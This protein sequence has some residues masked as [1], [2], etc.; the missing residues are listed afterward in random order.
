MPIQRSN[1]AHHLA[2]H[3]SE[4][5]PAVLSHEVSDAMP[6]EIFNEHIGI[7]KRKTEPLGQPFA[8]TTFPCTAQTSQNDIHRSHLL[9]ADPKMLQVLPESRI[10]FGYTPRLLNAHPRQSHPGHA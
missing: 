7:D 8:H 2:F 10:R 3:R 1:T 9:H 5:L 6:S 4:M